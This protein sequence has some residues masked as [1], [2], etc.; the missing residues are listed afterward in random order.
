MKRHVPGRVTDVAIERKFGRLAYVIESDAD[1][2]PETDVIID[3]ETGE[4]LG[5]EK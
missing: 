1:I 5:I 2:E 3:I 4:I